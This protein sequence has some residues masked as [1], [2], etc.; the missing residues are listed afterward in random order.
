M[1]KKYVIQKIV[2]S[3]GCGQKTPEEIKKIKQ[4]LETILNTLLKDQKPTKVALTKCKKPSAVFKIKKN[5]LLGFKVTLRKEKMNL[6]LK[7]LENL[8]LLKN[9]TYNNNCLFK[10]ISDHR[11]LKIQRFRTEVQDYGFNGAMIF[12]LKQIKT[13]KKKIMQEDCKK[14]LEQHLLKNERI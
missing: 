3:G 13:S 11:K 1:N 14:C 6:F 4:H 2:L 9:L 8:N 7:L 12:K 10:G 5:A